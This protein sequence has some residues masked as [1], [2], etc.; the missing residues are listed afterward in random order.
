M[1]DPNAEKPSPDHILR[2][3][4]ILNCIAGGTRTIEAIS[5][6]TALPTTTVIRV[7]AILA[8]QRILDAAIVGDEVH[9]AMRR[10]AHPLPDRH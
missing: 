6:A 1:F 3:T 10:R 7:A 4:A 9:L 5:Y 2:A 8:D